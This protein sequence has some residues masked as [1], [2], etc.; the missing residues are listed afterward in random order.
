MSKIR[1]S[2]FAHGNVLAGGSLVL[3]TSSQ[4]FSDISVFCASG[5]VAQN[6]Y[7]AEFIQPGQTAPYPVGM[8]VVI[9]IG[10]PNALT[11]QM[12]YHDHGFTTAP[13]PMH[14]GFVA[15]VPFDVLHVLG[16]NGQTGWVS[17]TPA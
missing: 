15:G 8:P 14:G 7:Y 12:N 6:V 9:N 1:L 3:D 2:F 16:G 5:P 17:V 4:T 13:I 10:T 11:V